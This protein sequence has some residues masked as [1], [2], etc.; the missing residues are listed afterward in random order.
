MD[1]NHSISDDNG[2]SALCSNTANIHESNNI[3]VSVEDVDKKDREN[4][5][6]L[7]IEKGSLPDLDFKNIEK[8]RF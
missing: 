3:K 4:Q 1:A 7:D 8:D 2:E 6:S 5:Y